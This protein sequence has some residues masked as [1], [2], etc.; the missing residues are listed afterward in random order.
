MKP[1]RQTAA[2]AAPVATGDNAAPGDEFT[3]TRI[4][5]L[6]KMRAML[7]ETRN[8]SA[9]LQSALDLFKYKQAKIDGS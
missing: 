5:R 2:A 9:Q 6:I 4:A 3:R 7:Q 1:I 8:R